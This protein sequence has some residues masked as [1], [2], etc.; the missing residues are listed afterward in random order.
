MW[1]VQY[2]VVSSRLVYVSLHWLVVGRYVQ[3]L[4]SM[5]GE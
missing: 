2:A 5:V 4:F 1:S 3:V